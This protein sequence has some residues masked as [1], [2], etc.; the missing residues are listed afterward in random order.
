MY[1]NLNNEGNGRSRANETIKSF[2]LTATILGIL[3]FFFFSSCKKE[4][5]NPPLNVNTVA[6]NANESNATVS[7]NYYYAS[8]PGLN[9]YTA[10]GA[11]YSNCSSNGSTIRARV[12]SFSGTKVTIQVNRINGGS[13]GNNGTLYLR[14]VSPCG[15]SNLSSKTYTSSATSI[16]IDLSLSNL[17]PNNSIS[18][19]PTMIS[20]NN[21]RTHTGVIKITNSCA[22]KMQWYSQV[23]SNWAD[24]LMN[25]SCK[26][27]AKGCV[28]S[29][30]AMLLASQE[31]NST[32]TYTP[33]TLNAFLN[34]NSGY[35][36]CDVSWGTAANMDGSGG[37]TYQGPNPS[38]NKWAWL[39]GELSQCRKVIVQVNSG[40]HWVL[41]TGRTGPSGTG[42]SYKVLDPG[43][44]TYSSKTLAHFNNT[45][46]Q[47]RSFDGTWKKNMN[48]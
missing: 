5:V 46:T 17:L 39:D 10:T 47:G 3:L 6:E 33:K 24:D 26:I 4:V 29:C 12:V 15:N 18:F 28:I 11:T 22:L 9:S 45:F 37:V 8:V 43:I 36:G 19:I 44:S 48:Y 20:S 13:F 31:G 32:S 40:S 42:S 21:S 7:A 23:N 30:I 16:T 35:S 2:R 14:E 38:S 34:S 27:R 25:N 1:K 41:I